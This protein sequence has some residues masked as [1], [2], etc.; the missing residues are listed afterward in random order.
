MEITID[1]H[2]L[3]ITETAGCASITAV[4]HECHRDNPMQWLPAISCVGPNMW[5]S[6]GHALH[7]GKYCNACS[8][9]M[10]TDVL[11][12]GIGGIES[13]SS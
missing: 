11:P 4:S 10:E 2:E 8:I 7:Q 12:V 13:Q 3:A 6:D 5:Q 1:H 9:A